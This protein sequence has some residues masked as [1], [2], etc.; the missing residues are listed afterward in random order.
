MGLHRA[1]TT[2]VT[3]VVFA[4]ASLC[5]P[6]IAEPAG[7]L[8]EAV[9][10]ARSTTVCQPLQ[11]SPQVEDVAKRVNQAT[12]DYY[13][14]TAPRQPITDAGP[15]LQERG[16]DVAKSVILAG[17]SGIESDAVRSAILEGHESIPD[18][19]YLHF[20]VDS[21]RDEVTKYTMT[22]VVLARPR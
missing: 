7:D 14:H 9:V 22:A 11:S 2:L 3:A 12:A 17:Y 1:V 19:S 20:G 13:R 18:C 6:A 10:A 5:A 16:Y 8:R 4:E 15:L 21:I